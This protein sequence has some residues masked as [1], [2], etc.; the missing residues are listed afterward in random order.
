MLVHPSLPSR[1]QQLD[2]CDR[3]VICLPTGALACLQHPLRPTNHLSS[4]SS[5]HSTRHWHRLHWGHIHRT[6]STALCLRSCPGLH[7]KST[8]HQHLHC[9]I[10]N[11]AQAASLFNNW[12]LVANYGRTIDSDVGQLGRIGCIGCIIVGVRLTKSVSS[13]LQ[14]NHG[15]SVPPMAVLCFG[16]LLQG[17]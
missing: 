16:M 8:R 3:H 4:H 17:S 1:R 12:L 13:A 5:A 11:L 14:D 2:F 6:H 7:T 15:C 9:S 10:P